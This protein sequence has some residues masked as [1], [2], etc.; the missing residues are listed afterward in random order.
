MGRFKYLE[1]RELSLGGKRYTQKWVG[2]RRDRD[3]ERER[4]TDRGR[5]T[6]MVWERGRWV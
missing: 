5:E 3:R 2:K 1:T 4:R 6:I